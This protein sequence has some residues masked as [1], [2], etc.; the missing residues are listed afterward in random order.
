MPYRRRFVLAAFPRVRGWISHLDRLV[1][2]AL[3]LL[4]T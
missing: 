4:L 1:I 3:A 2:S